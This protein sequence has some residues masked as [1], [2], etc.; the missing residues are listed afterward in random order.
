MYKKNSTIMLLNNVD[1]F[2]FD[3]TEKE[4]GYVGWSL[5]N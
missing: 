2:L 3:R 4:F 1:F 5:Q